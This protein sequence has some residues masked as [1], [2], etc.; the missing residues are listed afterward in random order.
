MIYDLYHLDSPRY[1]KYRAPTL[2]GVMKNIILVWVQALDSQSDSDRPLFLPFAF[3][4]EWVDCLKATQLH[5]NF[6]FRRVRVREYGWA[7]DFSDLE[8]FIS[9]PHEIES[10][11]PEILGEYERNEIM[12]ALLNAEVI[13]R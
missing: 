5:D 6:V 10:E 7:V 8:S 3:D 4:D 12:A 11:S 9:S 1:E 2:G 13:G